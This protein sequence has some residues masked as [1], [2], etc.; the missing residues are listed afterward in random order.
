M[1][2]GPSNSL[3]SDFVPSEAESR[4]KFKRSALTAE[5]TQRVFTAKTCLLNLFKEIIAV[6][7]ENRTT[8]KCIMWAE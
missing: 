6:Y 5:R 4:L 7:S 2:R 8:P 1:Y 3:K